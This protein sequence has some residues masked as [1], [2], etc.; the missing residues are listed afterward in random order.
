MTLLQLLFAF[1]A[2]VGPR[3]ARARAQKDDLRGI[4]PL[5]MIAKASGDSFTFTFRFP[6][7]GRDP[8]RARAQK[9]DLRGIR[10]LRMIAKASGDSFTIT[11]SFPGSGRA[12]A[13]ARARARKRTILLG[14]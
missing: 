5:R 8:A 13:R 12:P 7:S 2:P 14:I 4:R 11:F 1:E 6:G 10:P 3:R 9:D